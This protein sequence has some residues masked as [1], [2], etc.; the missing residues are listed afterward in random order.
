[1]STI[2]PKATSVAVLGAQLY[3]EIAASAFSA[4]ALT[5]RER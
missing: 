5:A 1:M 2:I 4:F 3:R